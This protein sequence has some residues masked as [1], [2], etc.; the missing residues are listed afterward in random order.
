MYRQISELM[1]C[2]YNAKTIE[3]QTLNFI[4][5][6][7][8]TI[9]G[10]KPASLIN[11]CSPQCLEL[12]HSL[13]NL[14]PSIQ[15]VRVKSCEH[16]AQFFIYHKKSL[17]RVLTKPGVAGYLE[18]LGYNQSDSI[19]NVV[20]L[21]TSKLC[22]QEFPHEVGLFLGYPLKDVLGFMGVLP[23]PYKKTMGWKMYGDTGASEKLYL[24][25]KLA[26]KFVSNVMLQEYQK[27]IKELGKNEKGYCDLRVN[28]RKHAESGRV[29]WAGVIVSRHQRGCSQCDGNKARSS[30]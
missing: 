26:R 30:S 28:N 7:G 19:E 13:N 4:E 27:L 29:D 20:S 10:V 14:N 11:V 15:T 25:F 17:A 9:V 6:I 8:V 21:L 1:D 22:S 24:K 12:C 2:L 5:K 18:A 23:L 16:S 3:I